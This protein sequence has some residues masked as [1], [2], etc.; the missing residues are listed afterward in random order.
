M[1]D[2]TDTPR[3]RIPG[4]TLL[5]LTELQSSLTGHMP[6]PEDLHGRLQ[7]ALETG[8]D[9]PGLPVQVRLAAADLLEVG[10][11][12]DMSPSPRPSRAERLHKLV[13]ETEDGWK[14]FLRTMA[15]HPARS[16]RNISS[17]TEYRMREHLKSTQ[18]L[19]TFDQVKKQGGGINKGAHGVSLTRAKYEQAPDGSRHPLG[20]FEQEWYFAAEVCHGLDPKRY[21]RRPSK[22][23]RDSQE[24]VDLFGRVWGQTGAAGLDDPAAAYVVGLRYGTL[25]EGTPL[26]PAPDAPTAAELVSKLEDLRER[27]AMICAAIDRELKFAAHPEWRQD[28]RRERT[29]RPPVKEKAPALSASEQAALDELREHPG[30]ATLKAALDVVQAH[31]GHGAPGDGINP[32]APRY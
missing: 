16:V 28:D 10:E 18:E 7:E 3:F 30:T 21:R 24:S 19:L 29:A 27:T 31:T 22:L 14:E 26:P 13:T 17:I 4:D 23:H 25:E 9:V 12:E 11:I 6:K 5:D 1:P 32:R 2:N 8:E 15:E 20:E